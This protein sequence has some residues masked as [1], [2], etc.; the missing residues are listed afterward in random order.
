MSL[1][2]VKVQKLDKNI[3][4]TL[5]NIKLIFFLQSQD[6]WDVVKKGDELMQGN[7]KVEKGA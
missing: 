1:Q 4:I 2:V 5:G 7:V 6:L 3:I